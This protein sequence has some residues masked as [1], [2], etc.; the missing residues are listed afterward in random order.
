MDVGARLRQ[1]SGSADGATLGVR[2][3]SWGFLGFSGPLLGRGLD[4]RCVGM[5]QGM[6]KPEGAGRSP[7]GVV[8]VC[9]DGREYG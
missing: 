8:R 1:R 5:L 4:Q 2:K 9:V 3:V 6:E 7:G